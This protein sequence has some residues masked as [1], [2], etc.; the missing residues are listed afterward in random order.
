MIQTYGGLGV[1]KPR[2]HKNSHAIVYTGKQVPPLEKNEF[3]KAGEEGMRDPML[4]IP[5]TKGERLNKMSRVNFENVYTLEKNWKFYDFGQVHTDFEH[6][7]VNNFNHIFTNRSNAHTSVAP[8]S[9][10]AP[11]SIPGSQSTSR[12]AEQ[13]SQLSASQGRPAF[14]YGQSPGSGYHQPSYSY[15]QTPGSTSNPQ[16]MQRATTSAQ[17]SYAGPSTAHPSQVPPHQYTYHIPNPTQPPSSQGGGDP[18]QPSWF[19]R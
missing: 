7:L 6:L 15:G 9:R 10:A 17:P 4:V 2:V 1:G 11:I 19:T 3:P 14:Q 16:W 18:N 8:A 5:T 13:S 12:S